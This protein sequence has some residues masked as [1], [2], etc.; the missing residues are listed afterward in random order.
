[1]YF[2]I[3]RS[4]ASLFS[5]LSSNLHTHDFHLNM[6]VISRSLFHDNSDSSSSN[7]TCPIP[8]PDPGTYYLEANQAMKLFLTIH[9]VQ[10]P[11]V[12]KLTFHQFTTIIS[13]AAALF[14][15][16]VSFYLIFRHA[17]HYAIPKEQKQYCLPF[18]SSPSSLTISE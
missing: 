1:M 14:A 10:V 7:H 4:C 5:A 2:M 17:T 18:L 13:G 12:G 8:G 3:Q 11:V 16:L 9:A 15:C 6:A